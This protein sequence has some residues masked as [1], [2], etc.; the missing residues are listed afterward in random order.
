[1]FAVPGW[2]L[3]PA[4]IKTQADTPTTTNE[5]QQLAGGSKKRKRRNNGAG[6]VQVTNTNVADLWK[7]HVEG[8]KPV[9]PKPNTEKKQDSAK[10]AKT[11]KDG[12]KPTSATQ[13][14]ETMEENPAVEHS[15]EQSKSQIPEGVESTPTKAETKKANKKPVKDKHI[16]PANLPQDLKP[17]P[18]PEPKLTPLQTAM[19]QKLI[20]ARFRHLNQT[21]YTAPS[22]ETLM[23]F[24]TNPTFF[25]E[26]HSGFRQQ[27]SAWP[28]NPVDGYVE[29]LKQRGKVKEQRGRRKQA[30]SQMPSEDSPEVA[31]STMK[32]LL[33]LPRTEGTCTIADLGCGDA[34][35]AS[36]MQAA[37]KKLN[38]RV[39]SYDLQSP[40]SLVTKADIAHLPLANGKAD[41]AIFCLALMGT[42]WVDFIDEAWRILH[43]KGELWVAEIKSRF[44]R[45]TTAKQ[46]QR[47]EHSVGKKRK[48]GKMDEKKLKESEEGA[49]KDQL[50][51]VV[52]GAEDN[53]NGTDVSAFV[54]VLRKRGF[55]LTGEAAVDLGNKMFVKMRFIKALTP[56]KG[57]NVKENLSTM[58]APGL[59]R[60]QKAQ[61]LDEENDDFVD[62][63]SVLKPC[64]YKIR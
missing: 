42:N 32:Q 10:R 26:Y 23:L 61:F 34:K 48:L 29:E 33:P 16:T 49:A 38:I 24:E 39:L 62:E 56:I 50:A 35:L 27:V 5:G 53:S 3:S 60:Q 58:A 15:N 64:L 43:W 9:K 11:S 31:T 18:K 13:N 1:M 40:N 59:R 14:S 19:R 55:E 51:V 7:E 2:S 25:D 52:D 20:S 46:H 28:E 30:V 12:E 57:K 21:L 37:G 8:I 41:V 54:A 22:T 36:Q 47:V 45:P 6:A 4:L 17:T 44:G 63:A